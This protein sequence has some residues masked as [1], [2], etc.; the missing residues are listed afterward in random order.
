M[1][2]GCMKKGEWH[3]SP[4]F[5]TDDLLL[6]AKVADLC[7]TWILRQVQERNQSF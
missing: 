4:S 5:G 6:I 3:Q 1:A 2:N 7:H